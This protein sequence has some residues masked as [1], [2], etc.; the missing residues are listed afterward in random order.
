MSSRQELPS[1]LP[2]VEQGELLVHTVNI[3]PLSLLLGSANPFLFTS[4]FLSPPQTI[5]LD[6]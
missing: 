2:L 3:A 5:G 1:L 6:F 4:L